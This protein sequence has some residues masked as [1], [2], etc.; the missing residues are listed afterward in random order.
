M[1][2]WDK[3]GKMDNLLYFADEW[4]TIEDVRNH[5]NLTS[6]ESW[7]LWR[8]VI[9][10]YD[11]FETRDS[12]HLHAGSPVEFRTSPAYYENILNNEKDKIAEAEKQ[13]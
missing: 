10:K 3:I 9:C 2:Y 7:K 6:A 13:K 11:E 4:K 1:T 5:F 8:R 12:L